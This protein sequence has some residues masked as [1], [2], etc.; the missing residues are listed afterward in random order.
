MNKS[1][2]LYLI[3]FICFN[4]F[5]TN[6]NKA[7]FLNKPINFSDIKIEP[8]EKELPDDLIIF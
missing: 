6:N 8:I 3:L 1:T 5:T 2:L 7:D 4:A